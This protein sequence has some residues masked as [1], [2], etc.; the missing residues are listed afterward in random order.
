MSVKKVLDFSL[1]VSVNV[2][3]GRECGRSELKK[4]V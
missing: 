2:G 4:K 3:G 1:K